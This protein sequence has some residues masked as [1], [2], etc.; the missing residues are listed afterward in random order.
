MDLGICLGITVSFIIIGLIVWSFVVAY[1][2]YSTEYILSKWNVAPDILTFEQTGSY[3]VADTDRILSRSDADTLFNYN[4]NQA[5]FYYNYL[6]DEKIKDSREKWYLQ[7]RTLNC[8][9]PDYSW[10]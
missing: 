5:P 8:S 1:E 6:P 9:Y 10:M 2:G 7:N 4:P 3:S